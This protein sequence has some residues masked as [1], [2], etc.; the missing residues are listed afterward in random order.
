MIPSFKQYDTNCNHHYVAEI[1]SPYP[2]SM[3]FS[4]PRCIFL[5]VQSKLPFVPAFSNNL[6]S[7]FELSN[8]SCKR[9]NNVRPLTLIADCFPGCAVLLTDPAA[10][11]AVTSP[12]IAY[13]PSKPVQLYPAYTRIYSALHRLMLLLLVRPRLS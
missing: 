10:P 7:H 1:L 11:T 6:S 5:P 3:S 13:A 2:L 9:Y 8:S 12:S 4:Q